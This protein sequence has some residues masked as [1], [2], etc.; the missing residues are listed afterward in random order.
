LDNQSSDNQVAK[1]I[2]YLHELSNTLREKRK[3]TGFFTQSRD[4]LEYEFQG[5]EP[6]T[7]SIK[8]NNAAAI[9]V[10]EFLFLANKSV[11]QKTSSHLPNHALLRR[12]AP[13]S[14]R[15]IVSFY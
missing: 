13:P 1:D 12:H 7:V 3:S 2:V 14:E 4:E 8:H 9:M 6:I 5:E 11:A 15:K 10:K